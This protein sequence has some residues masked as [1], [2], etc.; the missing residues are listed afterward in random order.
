M[1]GKDLVKRQCRRAT[2]AHLGWMRWQSRYKKKSCTKKKE[3]LRLMPLIQITLDSLDTA[4]KPPRACLDSEMVGNTQDEF[5]KLIL[6]CWR[7]WEGQKSSSVIYSPIWNVENGLSHQSRSQPLISHKRS[8]QPR[9]HR[10]RNRPG[11]WAVPLADRAEPWH[12]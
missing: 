3:H 8:T 6:G 4:D 12:H 10:R 1:K 11:S 5:L 7:R 9:G 2:S